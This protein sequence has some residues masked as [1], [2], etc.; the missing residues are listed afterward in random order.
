MFGI[1]LLAQ[2]SKG[3]ADLHSV[4]HVRSSAIVHVCRVSS[5]ISLNVEVSV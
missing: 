1:E 5:E 3:Q 2:V 4:L